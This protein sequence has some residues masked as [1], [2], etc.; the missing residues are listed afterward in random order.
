MSRSGKVSFEW[1]DNTYDFCLRAGELRDLQEKV[2]AGPAFVLDRLREG[3]WLVDDVVETIRL[4][5][6]GGGMTP[7]SA[8]RVVNRYVVNRPLLENV[9]VASTILMA[10]LVGS[11]DEPPKKV[12]GETESQRTPSSPGERSDLPSSTVMVLQ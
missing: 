4:G 11:E 1:A 10:S 2:D 7:E 12:E 9:G 3:T 5:L 8:R 6:I